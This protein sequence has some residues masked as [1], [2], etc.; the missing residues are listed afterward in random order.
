MPYINPPEDTMT[1]TKELRDNAMMVV[2]MLAVKPG[3]TDCAEHVG[4]YIGRLEAER[5]GALRRISEDPR[6][7]AGWT[8]VPAEPTAEQWQ[9][10]CERLWD[11]TE[12]DPV[13]AIQASSLRQLYRAI[14]AAAPEA[15]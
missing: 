5:D 8:L 15:K 9:E 13:L 2:G 12:D 6:V 4:N 10:F 7:P 14:I 3:W 1:E 11:T